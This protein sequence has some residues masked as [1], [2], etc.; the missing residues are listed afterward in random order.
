MDRWQLALPSSFKAVCAASIASSC[1]SEPFAAASRI[2]ANGPTASRTRA[3]LLLSCLSFDF[4][5]ADRLCF[6]SLS[7]FGQAVADSLGAP[8]FSR[9]WRLVEF[10]HL[11]VKCCFRNSSFSWDTAKSFVPRCPSFSSSSSSM[12]SH[13][14]GSVYMGGSPTSDTWSAHL[15]VKLRWATVGAVNSLCEPAASCVSWVFSKLSIRAAML[16][17]SARICCIRPNICDVSPLPPALL[18]SVELPTRLAASCCGSM[19]PMMSS[20]LPLMAIDCF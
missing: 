19:S 17:M 20:R 2:K 15:S 4:V 9:H 6:I 5:C 11:E 13:V 18:D 16:C 10:S 12:S 14:A 1:V 7:S 3:W 8:C